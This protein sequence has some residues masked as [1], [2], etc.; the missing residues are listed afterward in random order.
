V[1]FFYRSGTGKGTPLGS[2]R[3]QT[4]WVGDN[5]ACVKRGVLILLAACPCA[6]AL[7]PSLDINQYA[8][9]AWTIRDVFFG[10]P[11]QAIAQTPDGYLWLGTQTG[12]IRFDG[13]RAV[14]WTPPAAEPLPST[15]VLRLLVARDGTLW[16][17]TG[18]GLASWNGTRLIRY[19]DLDQQYVV[20]L[21]EDRDGTVWAG[22][23]TV[24]SGRLCAFRSGKTQ[25]YG[26]DDS[27]GRYVLSLFEDGAGNLW[28]G[29]E[30]GLW[31]WRPGPPQLY[32]VPHS[33]PILEIR[34]LNTT[35]DGKVPG[36][37]DRG[38][39]A[40]QP[41][42]AAAVFCAWCPQCPQSQEATPG[43][44]RRPLDRNHRWRGLTC[45]SRPDRR[46]FATGRAFRQYC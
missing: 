14:S 43:P 20:S 2:N 27:L 15:T 5:C 42:D 41:R 11:I 16:I 17:G 24:P 22:S 31:R 21:V 6:S 19:R 32:A 46:V 25:C 35:E 4:E 28:A 36:R 45:T 33:T 7:N 38:I 9:T 26:Q 18:A 30:T 40:V 1:T 12:L 13:V 37:Y 23:L 29:A 10:S 34:D 39:E 8:H 44:R 3:V